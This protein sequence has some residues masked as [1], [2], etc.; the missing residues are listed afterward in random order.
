LFELMASSSASAYVLVW[1][2]LGEEDKSYH[3]SSSSK[4]PFACGNC[5]HL[6]HYQIL[7]YPSF[8]PYA[9]LQQPSLLN[10]WSLSNMLYSIPRYFCLCF[11]YSLIQGLS[12]AKPLLESTRP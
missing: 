6:I 9:V 12:G 1:V 3:S 4:S 11:F 5:T 8:A 2:Y 7:E 10:L